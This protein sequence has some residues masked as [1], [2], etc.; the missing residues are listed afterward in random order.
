MSLFFDARATCGQCGT[1]AAERLAGSVNAD[2]RP[3]LRAE[4]LAGE[5]QAMTCPS[6]GT[7]LRL[8]VHLSY[9]DMGRGNWILAEGAERV[10]EWREVEA[11]GRAIFEEC[12][13]SEASPVV[14]GLG[15]GLRPRLVFG[16][17]ALREKLLCDDLGLDD[18]VVEFA[19][20]TML[21]T[22]P[23]A[24]VDVARE[25]RLVGGESDELHFVWIESETEAYGEGT[26]V[27]RDIIAEIELNPEPWREFRARLS[28]GIFVDL[29]RL[30]F[31]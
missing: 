9:L 12:Y 19:K 7:R 31:A 16:W 5:F 14:R 3:D 24:T 30:F 8:P 27:P 13:G 10:A 15:R 4:I 20:L 22:I 26:A 6:C 28:E 23:G 2:N 29:R 25:L 21:R 1:A 17:A 11:A 18:V